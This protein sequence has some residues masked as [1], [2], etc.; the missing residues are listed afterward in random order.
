MHLM[1]MDM[2]RGAVPECHN[3]DRREG[4]RPVAAPLDAVTEASIKTL[5][6]DFYARVRRD[7]A[8]GPVFDR[9]I[10]PEAWPAH[11]ERMYAFWSSVM[12]TSGHYKGDPV[13]VHRRVAGIAPPLFGNWL[14]LFEATAASLFVPAIADRFAHAARRIAESLILALFFRPDQPWKEDLRRRPAVSP[15]CV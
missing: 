10:A 6:D 12:L 15:S 11:L 2:T 14:D 5:V 4:D 3:H 8:L 9:A 13:G 1:G 7:P